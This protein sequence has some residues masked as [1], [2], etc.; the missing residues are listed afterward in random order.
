MLAP[1]GIDSPTLG[2]TLETAANETRYYTRTPELAP[3]VVPGVL[4]QQVPRQYGGWCLENMDSHGGWIAS[5]PDL[6]AF[7]DAFNAAAKVDFMSADLVKQVFQAAPRDVDKDV[8]YGFGWQ[9]RRLP[10]AGEINTWHTGSLTGTSTI[11]VRRHD[12][13]NWA[14][15]FNLRYGKNGKALATIVD[16]LVHRAAN[17]IS[18]WPQTSIRQTDR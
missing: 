9:V 1:L 6:V 16:P 3:G 17:R 2:R 8:Y 10:N 12:G 11:L 13:L 4:G 14:V 5:A 18:K 15:L 7:A